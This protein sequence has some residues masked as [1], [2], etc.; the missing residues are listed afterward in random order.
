MHQVLTLN[1]PKAKCSGH[2]RGSHLQ[3]NLGAVDSVHFYWNLPHNK[4][5]FCSPT[6]VAVTQLDVFGEGQFKA[7]NMTS[8]SKNIALFICFRRKAHIGTN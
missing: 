7:M 5:H 6:S 4:Q 3:I 2:H 8:K 1:I